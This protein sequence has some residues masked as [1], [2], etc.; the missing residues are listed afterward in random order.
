MQ[1]IYSPWRMK[2]IMEHK[3]NPECIFCTGPTEP[4][5]PDNL[6]I[7]RGE[8]AYVMLNRF[9]YTSGHLMVVP[10]LHQ[11]SLEGLEPAILTELM[12]LLTHAMGV[13][14]RV[15]HPEGFNMGANIGAAAGAGIAGHVHVH[16]VPRWS[17]DTNFMSA[18][19]DARVVP[20]DLQETFQRLRSAWE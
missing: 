2:Y 12:G 14:R 16:L 3:H 19:G 20:E 17:G 8:H 6:I 13:L 5:S 18:V 7:H 11:P 1:H 10:F 9:P 15:Y 4:D